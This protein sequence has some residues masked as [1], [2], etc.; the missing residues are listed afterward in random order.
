MIVALSLL[1]QSKHW[2]RFFPLLLLFPSCAVVACLLPH[3]TAA[4]RSPDPACH[5]ASPAGSVYTWGNNQYGQSGRGDAVAAHSVPVRIPALS[6]VT[7]IAAGGYHAIALRTDG[8]VLMWGDDSDDPG[9]YYYGSRSVYRSRLPIPIPGLRHVT[10]V[11]AG[12]DYSLA[13]R[14][15]G[16]VVAFGHN[17]RGQLGDGTTRNHRIPVTIPHLAGVVAIAAGN[18]HSLALTR[19]GR[20][21]AW[22]GNMFGQLGIGTVTGSR[23][24]VQI[25]GLPRIVAIAAG[26]YH[27]L[28][29]AQ[30]GHVYAWGLNDN[31]QL[32]DGSQTDRHRPVL[33]HKLAHVMA[34]AAGQGLPLEADSA[35][36]MEHPPHGS[37]EHSLALLHDGTVV[38]W[39]SLY[40]E[41]RA[42]S[43][44]TPQLLA[45]VPVPAP[46][47]T[48]V[49]A[50]AAASLFNLALTREGS[51]LAWGNNEDGELGRGALG[52]HTD[53]PDPLPVSILAGAT[54]IAAGGMDAYAIKR[55]VGPGRVH[56]AAMTATAYRA[57]ATADAV[58]AANA[59]AVAM[60]Y[61]T[62]Q[63]RRPSRPPVAT[64]VSVSRYGPAPIR[65]PPLPAIHLRSTLR[66]G[67]GDLDIGRHRVRL[68]TGRHVY[69]HVCVHDGGTLLAGTTL[70]LRARTI[71]VDAHSALIA[72]G[73]V[74]AVPN[75]QR[76]GCRH[77]RT[78]QHLGA[79]G[80]G[81]PPDGDNYGIG[82]AGQGGGT[83]TL[84]ASQV[85]IAGLLGADGTAGQTGT[86]V[87]CQTVCQGTTGDG[88]GGGSGGGIR[89]VAHDLQVTGVVSVVGGAGAPPA[90]PVENQ[91]GSLAV[92]KAGAP[93]KLG[94]AKLLVDVVR[95][96]SQHL[97]IAG[98]ASLGRTVPSDPVPPPL[99]AGVGMTY[100]A[101]TGH[102]LSGSFLLFWRRYGGRNT[103]GSPR[104]EPFLDGGRLA[105]YTERALMVLQD[106]R[107]HLAPLGRVLTS[108]RVFSRVAPFTSANG[109]VYFPATGHSLS[110]RFLAYWRSHHGIQLLG[111]PISE[112]VVAN[113][114]D[115]SGRRY[116][117]QW[118]E[119]GR[120]EYH[121]ENAPAYHM[122]LGLLGVRALQRRGWLP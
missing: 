97:P 62:V 108:G 99:A 71:Y 65:K 27:S 103:L 25:G 7:A 56:V 32:G 61:A 46:H 86:G 111:A 10:A 95:F 51:V 96:P 45:T 16:T 35:P 119:K 83:I 20:V 17:R 100:D 41:E 49:T 15:D 52:Y 101:S 33:V 24:P 21:Y 13:L 67:Q 55:P 28:A 90:T 79:P 92:G 88:G 29:L 102:T 85:V 60:T 38:E 14:A 84:I 80:A 116:A 26:G 72:T 109:R 117:M 87:Y 34:I 43:L 36:E 77:T 64:P 104:S 3:V 6:C 37:F 115:G 42:Y 1:A 121:P 91:Y 19:D 74:G 68:L 12:V 57:F 4:S 40:R 81:A 53:S 44:G 89:V 94:C 98:Q 78:T 69:R 93:G 31:G 110:G 30:D 82:F 66:C 47:L 63:A 22:G 9:L 120:L 11:A 76:P 23:V 48:G 122:Q 5:A 118:F 39:G 54:S 59:T 106:G 73:T 112:V 105:Q 107:V 70:T 50:I 18:I 75:A 113:N 58:N 114:G 8:T 2:R